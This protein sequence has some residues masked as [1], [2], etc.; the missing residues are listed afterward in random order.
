[1][2]RQTSAAVEEE[3]VEGYAGIALHDE[4]DVLVSAEEFVP[5]ET[6]ENRRTWVLVGRFLT[7]RMVKLEFMRERVLD[8]GPWSFDNHTLVCTLVDDG[9]LPVDMV[10]D[11]V[12]MWVQ[13]QVGNFLGGFVKG[14]ERFDD[15][16]WKA[17]YRIR[18]SIP[19]AKPL[20]RRM[21]LASRKKPDF[22]FL[23][24]T[25]VGRDHAE[26][27]RVKLGFQGLFYVD[28]RGLSGGL[29]LL[30]KTNDT[31]EK[32]GWF[33]HPE[34][35]LRGFGEALD[36]CGLVQIP[37]IGY[38]FTWEKGEGTE[39]WVEEKLDMVVACDEWRVVVEGA[40]VYNI[41]T[42]RSDHSALFLD[43]RPG[44]GNRV[45]P[46]QFRF[47]M[48]WLLDEGCREVVEEAWGHGIEDLQ[49]R[50]ERCGMRLQSWGG[51]RFLKF[52][53]RIASLKKQK[54]N[55]RGRMSPQA[56][57][58]FRR[59][60][61][62][63]NLVQETELV[64]LEKQDDV[65]WRQRAKQYWLRGA[66]A[67]TRFYHR[68]ASARKRKNTILRL[69]D[70]LGGWVD[71]DAM[72]PVVMNYFKDIFT[73]NPVVNDGS[74]FFASIS[75]RVTQSH[76]DWLNRPYDPGEV[77]DALFAMFPDKAPGP[78]GMNPGFYQKFWDIVGTDVTGFMLECLNM[79]AFP[80]GLNESNIVLIPKTQ[81]PEMVTDLRLITLSNVVYKVAAKVIA[82]RM[83]PLLGDVISVSQSA[84]IP[85][86]LITDNILIAAEVGHFLNRKQL[87]KVGWGAL[88]LD[89]AKAY[90][91]MEWSFLRKM[92][93]ALGFQVRWVNLI[94]ECVT[95]VSY[96]VMI[97]G[98]SGEGLSLLLQQALDRGVVHGLRVARG[99]P[100][101]SH[102]F[103]ADDSLLF[104]KANVDEAQAT[105]RCLTFYEEL[106][107]Q[108]IKYHKLNICFSRNT[109]QVDRDM[110]AAVFGVQQAANF[111]KYLGLP[112]FVG[113]NKRAVFAY[114]EDKERQRIGSWN[115]KLLPRAGK[116]VLLKSVAQPDSLCKN[117]ECVMNKFWWRNGRD[118]GGIHWLAW[119]KLSIPKKYG[120]LGFKDLRAF[121]LAMLGKQGWRFLN[122]PQSLVAKVYKARYYPNSDF[123][124]APLLGDSAP[125]IVS[126][127]PPHLGEVKVQSGLI[128]PAS[129]T[130][131][132]PLLNELFSFEDVER[133]TTIP[134][135]P[136]FDDLWYWHGYPKGNYTVKGAYCE[137][138]GTVIVPPVASHLGI[139]IWNLKAPPKWKV[140][141]WRAS[142]VGDDFG[143][144]L[145][146]LLQNVDENHFTSMVAIMYHIWLQLNSAVWEFKVGRPAQVHAKALASLDAWRTAMVSPDRQRQHTASS[147]AA[148]QS[149]LALQCSFDAAFSAATR[150]WAFGLVL[151][152]ADDA[153]IATKN[154]PLPLC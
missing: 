34:S 46:Q 35:L 3:L 47:E 150:R 129:S 80:P 91:R 77:R 119:D 135:S 152:D 138:M 131:D 64:R 89:M 45:G 111:G 113:R 4:D 87:G 70:D 118:G 68:Y 33:Q 51:D 22:I 94:M 67:N 8:E 69:R 148:G 6:G 48:A 145:E 60:E 123:L 133:I 132:I 141:L 136:A 76:N 14:D 149:P 13:E 36:D 38:Q 41:L 43:I 139:K 18:V 92:M 120:G 130:W 84:F 146:L 54:M 37:M 107:G 74:G 9:I 102:F 110:V 42:R 100:A 83:K 124:N 128:D 99:A 106:S 116:E 62:Y 49:T 65:F 66:D 82:N 28:N 109:Q 144:W 5:V 20:R 108:T 142:T 56:L 32:R 140:F 59:L 98:V 95:T 126:D 81:S 85:G 78:D 39:T 114:V 73:V 153:F 71:G 15:R 61:T 25:K 16:P 137:L 88:K 29:A 58:D 104:F 55:C 122:N 26:W 97:N 115:K 125:R 103:F 30:W 151:Q 101:L 72:K 7:R 79:G 21:K 12:D 31:Y 112:A 27:L 105:K 75:T 147:V 86:R 143:A 117:L 53:E 50:L 63:M 93:L 134:I 40:R 44:V 1:M 19:V 57:E 24:E 154:S 121:N 127:K 2:E 17:F 11:S 96:N 90:N 23:M 52:G 10:L